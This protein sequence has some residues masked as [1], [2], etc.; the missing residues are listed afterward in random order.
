MDLWEKGEE[1]GGIERGR[2]RRVDNLGLRKS[3]GGFIVLVKKVR[4]KMCF[5]LDHSLY[6]LDRI[7][8]GL[9]T[10]HKHN[11]PSMHHNLVLCV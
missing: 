8:F 9:A 7:G 11:A 2:G 5:L 6:C 10:Q 1:E 4:L 3:S